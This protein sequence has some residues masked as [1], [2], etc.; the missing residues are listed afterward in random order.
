MKIVLMLS[1]DTVFK[2]RL[3]YQVLLRRA[4]DVCLVAEVKKQKQPSSRNKNRERVKRPRLGIWGLRGA[5]LFA[6]WTLFNKVRSALPFPAALRSTSTVKRVASSFEIPY[7][8][9]QDICD[10]S[11]IQLVEQQQPDLI[12]SFQHQIF[13]S[14]H[15]QIPRLACLNCH[16]ALLPK[17][18][19]NQPI[20]WALLEGDDRIGVTVHTM[21]EKIDA[22]KVVSQIEMP[23]YPNWTL[24]QYYTAVHEL[25]AEAILNAIRAVEQNT[26]SHFPDL[27][28]NA[29]YYKRPRTID[30]E[31]SR[32]LGIRAA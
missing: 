3:L 21:V 32:E 14:R 23:V 5:M 28:P 26:I 22:G 2:P 20:F 25:G 27:D 29:K 4:Q 16:P 17:Y 12:I 1:H 8:S 31:K 6:A 24:A 13:T 7:V 30:L 18:R 9:V 15:L 19:G 10:E 11:F